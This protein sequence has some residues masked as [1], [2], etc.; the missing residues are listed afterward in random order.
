MATAHQTPADLNNAARLFAQPDLLPLIPAEIAE[1]VRPSE[2][3]SRISAWTLTREGSCQKALTE[4]LKSVSAAIQETVQQLLQI[5]STGVVLSGNAR[6]FLDNASLTRLA[7]KK[8]AQGS[9]ARM[10]CCA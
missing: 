4:Q 6:V 8:P 9:S 5:T 1:G 3:D 10:K 2:R 7:C